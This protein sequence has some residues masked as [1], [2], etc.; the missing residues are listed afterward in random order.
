MKEPAL[1]RAIEG[2][3]AIDAFIEHKPDDY[4]ESRSIF[5]EWTSVNQSK[6]IKANE[7]SEALP[8]TSPVNNNRNEKSTQLGTEKRSAADTAFFERE[9][10]GPIN[11]V[12]TEDTRLSHFTVQVFWTT[13]ERPS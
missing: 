6:L 13:A 9:E 1:I 4:E 7:P 2:R 3:S 5:K 11:P 10:E 12:K 8:V